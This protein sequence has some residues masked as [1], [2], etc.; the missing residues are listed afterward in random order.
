[1]PE[2]PLDDKW[3][4]CKSVNLKKITKSSRFELGWKSNK[5]SKQG[6]F[7]SGGCKASNTLIIY[8]NAKVK[9]N[10]ARALVTHAN[11]P[12]RLKAKFRPNWRM[13]GATWVES[14]SGKINDAPTIEDKAT[15][16]TCACKRCFA[17]SSFQS[18]K[19]NY[20]RRAVFF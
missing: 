15:T 5:E 17:W 10:K 12:I 16:G 19:L 1:M 20:Q 18:P 4:M 8:D 7:V 3:N 11:F 6:E 14:K 2:G 9:A 13:K